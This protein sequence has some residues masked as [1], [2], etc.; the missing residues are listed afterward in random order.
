[1]ETRHLSFVP[2]RDLSFIKIYSMFIRD[3]YPYIPETHAPCLSKQPRLGPP[4]HPYIETQNRFNRH[5]PSES[6]H[7]HP[8]SRMLYEWSLHWGWDIHG[9]VGRLNFSPEE[10]IKNNA[11]APITMRNPRR[12]QF[13]FF[14]NHTKEN[15]RTK[16]TTSL[17][18]RPIQR[19]HGKY[20]RRFSFSQDLLIEGEISVSN[21]FAT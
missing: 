12:I 16:S 8:L 14:L 20:S 19:K 15:S 2:H 6:L 1:M 4:L 11:N 13:I 7:F 5:G 9:R 17:P 10:P 18:L 3:P 21:R